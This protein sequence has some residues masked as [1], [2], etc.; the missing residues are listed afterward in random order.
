MDR[1]SWN[2]VSTLILYLDER[3]VVSRLLCK[4]VA[5]S[6]GSEEECRILI[7]LT[8]QA[9]KWASIS[10][11]PRNL[12]IFPVHNNQH[13]SAWQLLQVIKLEMKIFQGSFRVNSFCPLTPQ[14]SGTSF[15]V[16]VAFK[17]FFTISK[18]ISLIFFS[19]AHFLNQT[20]STVLLAVKTLI[21]WW[22][23]RTPPIKKR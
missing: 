13:H 10:H 8:W 22:Y 20:P 4:T 5:A 2:I 16:R 3:K 15:T 18:V 19:R 17:V 14:S 11:H 21:A 9:V 12:R 7:G 6:Y 23:S 1:E